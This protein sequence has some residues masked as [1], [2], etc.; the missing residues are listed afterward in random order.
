VTSI[1]ASVGAGQK[2]PV[3]AGS[4]DERATMTEHVKY[5]TGLA[6]S[7]RVLAFGPVADPG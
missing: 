7:G 3:M 6:E 5:W 1:A 2:A 4:D